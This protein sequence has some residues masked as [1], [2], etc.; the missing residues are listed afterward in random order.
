MSA[1]AES[2]RGGLLRALWGVVRHRA[3]FNTALVRS[4]L[5]RW[6]GFGNLPPALKA[7][8]ADEGEALLDEGVASSITRFRYRDPHRTCAWSRRSLTA[9]IAL[10]RQRLVSFNHRGQPFINVPRSDPRLAQLEVKAEGAD[11]LLIAFDVA[12]FHP[13][14]SGRMECRFRTALAPRLAAALRPA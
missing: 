5:N 7:S 6:F 1:A 12:L 2:R 4:L 8:L 11:R 3:I 9:S 13:D 10:T 14:W